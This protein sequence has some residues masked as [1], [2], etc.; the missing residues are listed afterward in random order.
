MPVIILLLI[1]FGEEVIEEQK[2]KSL[3]ENCQER[4]NRLEGDSIEGEEG[5]AAPQLKYQKYRIE[6]G[7]YEDDTAEWKVCILQFK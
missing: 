7:Y 4:K 5:F 3:R 2:D 6:S 1:F